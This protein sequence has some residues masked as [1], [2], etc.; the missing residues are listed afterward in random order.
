MPA[1]VD[2][3]R[4]IAEPEFAALVTVE[5]A[6]RLAGK[7]ALA[8]GSGD[9]ARALALLEV[10]VEETTTRTATAV[11]S[12]GVSDRIARSAAADVRNAVARVDAQ[13][14]AEAE[15]RE[16]ICTGCGERPGEFLRDGGAAWL[17]PPCESAAGIVRD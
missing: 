16:N 5:T 10:L 13:L 15:A 9:T 14:A 11:K 4:T 17:C 1:T 2:P 3:T 8:I 7:V 6:E 12:L